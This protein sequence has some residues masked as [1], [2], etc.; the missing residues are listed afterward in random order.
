MNEFMGNIQGV[1]DAKEEG[2]SPGAMSMHG[3][4]IG[5]G[6]EKDVFEKASNAE[7]KPVKQTDTMS[8]MF[9]TCLGLKQVDNPNVIMHEDAVY[10][11]CWNGLNKLA[12]L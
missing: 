12:K 2:F 10:R 5:H 4:F 11:D 7:L 3:T 1:Q 9:E 6:P 8:F